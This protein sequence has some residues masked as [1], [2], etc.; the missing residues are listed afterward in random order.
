MTQKFNLKDYEK[1]D[2]DAVIE[3][4]LKEE[5]TDVNIEET[6]EEQLKPDRVPEKDCTIE[7]LLDQGRSDSGFEIIE[8][9]LN[10]KKAEFDIKLRNPEAY[11][12][13]INKLE[14]KRLSNDPVEDEPYE[15]ASE[16]PTKL[17]WW[18]TEKKQND[19]DIV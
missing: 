19:L 5:H 14:E 13:D 10:T 17:R 8:R 3:H 4:R 1:I 6:T 12:G 2:G 7:A 18:E 11:E 9:K 16:T 15:A